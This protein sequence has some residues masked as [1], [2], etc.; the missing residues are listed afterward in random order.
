MFRLQT[1]QKVLDQRPDAPDIQSQVNIRILPQVGARE[2]EQS[3]RR[4]KAVFLQMNKSARQLNQPFV[5]RAV[6]S[7]TVRQP[8]FF[9]YVVRFVKQAPV[10]AFQVAEKVRVQVAP[11]TALNPYG[12]LRAFF[13][14][15]A[16]WS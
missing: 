2:F 15:P 7:V 6:R 10:E 4:T 14:H 16:K 8:E 13:S 1:V 9:Q 3:R 12:D 5:K 11:S